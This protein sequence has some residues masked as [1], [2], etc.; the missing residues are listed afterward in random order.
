MFCKGMS[1]DEGGSMRKIIDSHSHLHGGYQGLE[2]FLEDSRTLYER[3]GAGQAVVAGAPLWS[4]EYVNQNPLMMLF[5]LKNP[6][7]VY[8]YAGLDYYTPKGVEPEDFLRQVKRF[9]AMG[10]DGIKLLEM[11]PMLLR[12]LGQAWLSKPCYEEMFGYLEEKQ[13]PV[14]L[15]VN[16][17]ETFWKRE[18]CPSF[19][20]ERGWCYEDESY[21]TKEE[22]YQEMEKVLKTHPRLK[23]VLAHFYFLSDDIRR[24][25][26]V[27]ETFPKVWFDLTPG[28]EMYQNFAKIPE[29]WHDFF[30]TYQNR[31]L[32]GTDN[33]GLSADGM[34]PME[35]KIEYARKNVKS[36]CR[37]L[38]TEDSFEGYGFEMKGIGLPDDAVD[39]ICYG[40]FQTMTGFM[41]RMADVDQVLAYTEELLKRYKGA[42]H[43]TYFERS[44]PLLE[45]IYKE[46]KTFR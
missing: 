40:N 6:G 5:K 14:L 34:T 3:A 13:I 27:M 16:D 24:A 38:E 21:A 15:H 30:L 18:T 46:L 17:P 11:K 28:T 20:I 23:V 26:Y 37:F 1:V 41:P 12:N 2:Q 35:E 19:V 39:K 9:M 22:I 44:Y 33:G 43:M 45:Q 31:I 29:Q 10:Y 42:Y 7:Q 8:A 36:I 4:P 32:L 25:E